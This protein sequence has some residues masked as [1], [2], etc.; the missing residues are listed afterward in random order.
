MH[1]CRTALV[2]EDHARL[3]AALRTTL[4]RR[5]YRVVTAEEPSA[6]EPRTLHAID[7]VVLD[8]T[9]PDPH[10]IEVLHQ[11]RRL[12]RDVP[13]IGLR[14]SDFLCGLPPSEAI[15]GYASRGLAALN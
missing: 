14:G 15:L 10:G 11:L 3:R 6:T 1:K 5:G 13:V 2:V 12:G 7:V 8:L 9:M 4:E